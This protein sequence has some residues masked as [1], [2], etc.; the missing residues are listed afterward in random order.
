[1][2][3]NE[4]LYESLKEFLRQKLHLSANAHLKPEFLIKDD[5]IRLKPDLAIED[6]TDRYIIEVKK[7]LSIVSISVINLYKDLISKRS[8]KYRY[9][10]IIICKVSA[11]LE[12]AVAKA[13]GIDVLLLPPGVK[14]PE[15][16]A[17]KPSA[18][19]KFTSKKSW[20]VISSLLKEKMSSIRQISLKEHV[21]YGWSH[22]TIS[23]LLSQGIAAR[24]DDLIVISDMNKLLNGIAWERPF[25]NLFIREIKLRG[26]SAFDTAR[27]ISRVT[28]IE[29]IDCSFTSYTAAGLYTGYSVRGDTAY[30]Y[31]KNQDIGRLI[32]ILS[33]DITNDGVTVRLYLPDRDV[34]SDS[35]E[36]ED[37]KVVSPGQ[38][39]LDI[40]GQGYSSKD[41]TKMMVDKYAAL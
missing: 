8:D 33:E 19:I 25:E 21:S 30:A 7:K 14:M 17:A 16:D 23:A 35:K 22:K 26:K 40:A 1:M 27:Y 11:P 2:P 15:V 36:L 24:K 10:Y 37:V 39:L 32:D 38:T 9:R 5:T 3:E 31:M 18:G 20:A 28:K 41:V 34:F 6:S 13:A 4:K 12:E 29:N